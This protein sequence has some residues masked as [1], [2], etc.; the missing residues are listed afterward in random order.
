M[1]EEDNTCDM[2][3]ALDVFSFSPISLEEGLKEYPD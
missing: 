3:E 1:L 2:K